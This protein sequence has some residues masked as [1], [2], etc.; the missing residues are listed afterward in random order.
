MSWTKYADTR[1]GIPREM[2][3]H[4]VLTYDADGRPERGLASKWLSGWKENTLFDWHSKTD[5]P[6]LSSRE[7]WQMW[8]QWI[9][10]GPSHVFIV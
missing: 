6:D 8:E 2:E 10:N 3:Y 1:D 7:M 5:G 9:K 4:A